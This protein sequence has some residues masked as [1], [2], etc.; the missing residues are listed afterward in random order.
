MAQEVEI[1]YE[2]EWLKVV[3]KPSNLIV[4]HSKYARNLDETSL[5]QLV[6]E[7]EAEAK[8]HPIHRLDRKTSGLIIFAKD[9]SIIPL[10]Q[11]LFDQQK[12]QKTYIALVRGF[13]DT[14]GTLDYPIRADEETVY[15]TAETVYKTIHQF[16]IQIPVSPYP[17]A[18]YSILELSPKTGRMHQLRKH[19]NKF[20]HPII[21]DPKYGNR[22]HNHMF[23]EKLG[24]SNLFL[25]AKTLEFIHPKTLKLIKINA[26]FPGFWQQFS[27]AFN[28]D[29]QLV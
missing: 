11:D 14:E 9:K 5:C 10:F 16:E 24:I 4:H 29:F 21:G 27:S 6:N 3:N 23:I 26:P 12:I 7:N 8:S 19:M 18:R 20:S 13:V 28:I 1:V 15:K 25:H 2:D 22:H 17:T